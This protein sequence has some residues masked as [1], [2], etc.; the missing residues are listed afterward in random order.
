M[1][2]EQLS[3]GSVS[4]VSGPAT[5]AVRVLLRTVLGAAI[6]VGLLV[7]G[8]PAALADGVVIGVSVSERTTAPSNPDT[9]VPPTG[10]GTAV[11][12]SGTSDG[13]TPG[14]QPGATGTGID[15]APGG[16]SGNGSG[17]GSGS[18]SGDDLASTGLSTF[19]LVTPAALLLLA[20]AVAVTLARRRRSTGAHAA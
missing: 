18:G 9:S 16:G 3:S 2:R 14:G 8:G 13:S 19:W 11:A 1:S 4:T 7:S 20:G 12:P 5:R 10:P 17:P 15:T 6:A